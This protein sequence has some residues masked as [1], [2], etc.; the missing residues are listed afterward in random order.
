MEGGIDYYGFNVKTHLDFFL[1]V[2]NVNLKMWDSLELK[3]IP[4]VELVSLIFGM[5]CMCHFIIP[6]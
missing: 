6:I 2:Q 4:I 5:N 1:Y 3:M